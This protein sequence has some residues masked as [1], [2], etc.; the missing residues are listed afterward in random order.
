[1]ARLRKL[2]G[3]SRWRKR[4]ELLAS[5][6]PM[7]QSISPRSIVR[8]GRTW[9]QGIQDQASALRRTIMARTKQLVVCIDND[10]YEASLERRKI[11]VALRD[12]TTEKHALVRLIDESGDDY[13]Y[14]KT[15]FREI[16]LPRAVRKAVLS[17]A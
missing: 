7:A 5:G 11:Y 1:M 13:L 4:K 14:P 2:Y 9:A 8:S 3:R 10:G 17:A 12:S 16:E 15:F 6:C